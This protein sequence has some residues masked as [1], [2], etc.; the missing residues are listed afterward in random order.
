[1][2]YAGLK[3]DV[4]TA[5]SNEKGSKRQFKLSKIENPNELQKTILKSWLGE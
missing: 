2:G 3:V 5:G 4:Q 1:L